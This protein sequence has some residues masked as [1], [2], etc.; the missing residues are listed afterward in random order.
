MDGTWRHLQILELPETFPATALIESLISSSTYKG[1]LY[2][3]YGN[4]EDAPSVQE[5]GIYTKS[6]GIYTPPS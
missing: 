5:Y 1:N 3:V 2:Q 4:R 6:M